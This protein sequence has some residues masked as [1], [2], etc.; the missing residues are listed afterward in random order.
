MIPCDA[1]GSRLLARLE[2]LVV[3]EVR[4]VWEALQGAASGEGAEEAALEWSR[5][6]GRAVLEAGVQ[7]R[8]E[9]VQQ[10]ETGACPCGGKQQLHSHRPRT[11]LTLLGALRVTRQYRQCRH[12]GRRSFP[13][14]G[15]LGWEGAFS[16]RLEEAVAWSAAALPYRAAL[17]GLQR[18]CGI[19]LS[20]SAA[21]GIAARWGN[22]RLEL[23]GY[24]E[25]VKGRL[26]VEIDGSMAHIDGDWREVKLGSFLRWRA[27]KPEA[28]SD[29]ADWLNCEQFREPLW[30]EALVRG[31]PE[32]R[33]VVVIADGAAWIW[34]TANTLF[35]RATEILDW[36]HACEHLWQAGRVI[37]GEATPE[38][39]TLV[40]RWKAALRQG[41]SEGLE[42][43]IRELA[44]QI[45]D[46]Q[47]VL[48]KTADYLDHHQAR[49]RYPLFRQAGWPIGS[50]IVEG[51]CKH[52][53]GVRFKR[54]SARWKKP[55]F[56]AIL[57]LRL[58]LLNNR[59]E[60]RYDLLR[61]AA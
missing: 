8:V 16:R 33:Q 30:S 35:P 3:A 43:E 57:H 41:Y 10:A 47:E 55:G 11:V 9:T 46:P 53:I 56:R 48:R 39:H 60:K 17:E 6:V 23:A 36:Y 32:A 40:K 50:G 54:K 2:R 28:I 27:G 7:A 58:D 49:L 4:S 20:L 19:E 21:Q 51:G 5:K 15:W 29:V 37:H 59:W 1:D 14:D 25:P 24:A 52:V 13:A 12:C 38:T 31:A 34:Q 42:E 26:G 22:Q 18:F 45:R 61:K 44:H